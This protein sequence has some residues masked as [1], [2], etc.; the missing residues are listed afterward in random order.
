MEKYYT[1][2]EAAPLI[3]VSEITL[4][5]WL[6]AGKIKGS[7]LGRKW[8]LSESVIEK[9]IEDSSNQWKLLNK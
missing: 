4:K 5:R 7:K 6:I 9:M 8:I 2:K 1:I 3:K